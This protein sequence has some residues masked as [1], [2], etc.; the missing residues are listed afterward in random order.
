MAL[1]KCRDNTTQTWFNIIITSKMKNYYYYQYNVFVVVHL[2]QRSKWTR[3]LWLASHGTINVDQIEVCVVIMIMI[4]SSCHILVAGH[5]GELTEACSLCWAILLLHSL[6]MVHSHV[7]FTVEKGVRVADEL[8][9]IILM[10]LNEVQFHICLHLCTLD[11]LRKFTRP[12]PNV[13]DVSGILG[14][15]SLTISL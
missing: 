12:L 15:C 9:R 8:N 3:F 10:L 7:H 4:P 11:W 13:P 2:C 1:T 5:H 6:Q 14:K